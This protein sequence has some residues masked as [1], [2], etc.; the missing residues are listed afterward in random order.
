[1]SKLTKISSL[2]LVLAACQNAPDP[3]MSAVVSPAPAAG[4]GMAQLPRARTESASNPALA[5]AASPSP[6]NAG[7]AA[8][9]IARANAAPPAS[10]PS[11]A[12][13]AG[14]SSPAT[15]SSDDTA[16]TSCMLPERYARANR[17]ALDLS[18]PETL[19]WV[20]GSGQFVAWLKNTYQRQP[21]GSTLVESRLCGALMPIMTSTDFVGGLKSSAQIPLSTFDNPSLPVMH[22]TLG[23][24]THVAE[25][26]D[27]T[28]VLGAALPDPQ[29]A[30]PTG[31]ALMTADDDGDGA[32]GMTVLPERGPEFLE[33]PT[34]VSQ[35][36]FIDRLYIAAR[37]RVVVTLTPTCSGASDGRVEPLAFDSNPVGCHVKDRDDCTPEEL[38]FV[39]TQNPRYKLG[40]SGSWVEADI[41]LDASCE[42]VRATMP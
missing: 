23:L 29:G 10:S 16:A 20:A 36:E 18:W 27:L 13:A 24:Q 3:Q 19:I 15:P 38:R 37:A 7:S 32:P 5:G 1:M 12:A 22:S 2:G 42:T 34:S 8:E 11:A 33:P 39:N 31:S 40:Q 25:T 4:S 28:M 9:P 35:L 41:P 26:R 6:S 21:D 30:W 17:V 14:S